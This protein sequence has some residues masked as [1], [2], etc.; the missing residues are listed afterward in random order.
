MRGEKHVADPQEVLLVLLRDG[1]ARADAGMGE[2]VV[3][4]LVAV[5]EPAQEGEM[6]GGNSAGEPVATDH[7]RLVGV[8]GARRDAVADQRFRAAVVK[9]EGGARRVVEKAEQH[10]LVIAAKVDGLSAGNRIGWSISMSSTP[11]LSSP[12]SM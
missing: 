10:L 2:E 7:E 9:P 8:H 4:R 11:R 5:R 3:A 12:R 6:A 1:D